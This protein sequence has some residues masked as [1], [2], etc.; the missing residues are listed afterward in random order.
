[1]SEIVNLRAERLNRGLTLEQVA[2]RIGI[3]ATALSMLERGKNRPS[4]GVGFR[5]AAEYGYRVT[6]VWPSDDEPTEAA[7]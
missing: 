3:S 1:M 4:P 7:A 5:L 2:Q 6:D